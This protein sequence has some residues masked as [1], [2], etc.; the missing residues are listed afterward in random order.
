MKK[1]KKHKSSLNIKVIFTYSRQLKNHFSKM[2]TSFFLLDGMWVFVISFLK[3]T[4]DSKNSSYH[5]IAPSVF[6]KP[7]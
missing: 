5:H 6:H 3:G 2:F 1:A 4:Q 7:S